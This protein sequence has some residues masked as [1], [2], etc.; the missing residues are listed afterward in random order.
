MVLLAELLPHMD[1][2]T[3]LGISG[4]FEDGASG[5]LP[6]YTSKRALEDFLMGLSQDTPNV[7]VYGISPSDTATTAYDK[8]YPEYANQSQPPEAVADLVLLLLH[9]DHQ[10]KSGDIIELKR[11][12][13]RVAFHA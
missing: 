5:W 6:Y 11:G 4:T 12:H 9:G 8:F 13:R 7:K 2:G 1:H 3:V 10:Y